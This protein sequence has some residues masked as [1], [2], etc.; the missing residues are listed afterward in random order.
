MWILTITFFGST[1]FF[2]IDKVTQY[3]IKQKHFVK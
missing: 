2:L 1:E 3:T